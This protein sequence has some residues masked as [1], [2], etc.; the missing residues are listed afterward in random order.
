MNKR[1]PIAD[2]PGLFLANP[3]NWP[4][5]RGRVA[6]IGNGILMVGSAFLL[7]LFA[8]VVI[9]VFMLI[10]HQYF[11]LHSSGVI[12]TGF[13]T[14]LEVNRGSRSTGYQVDYR[15]TVDDRSYT[16]RQSVHPEIFSHLSLHQ[17][18][19]V[20]YLPR[21]PQFSQ[22]HEAEDSP[23]MII[24]FLF[25][26]IFIT[27]AVLLWMKDRHNR[28]L[29]RAGTLILG[30]LTNIEAKRGSKA[31]PY[32]EVRYFFYNEHGIRLEGKHFQVRTDLS[33]DTLP[34]S[35]TP[36]AVLYVDDSTYRLM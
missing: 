33:R 30:E 16:D 26:A 5:V 13:I 11:E 36:V 25:S 10:N 35:G 14:N 15:Y 23:G 29:S 32:I 24:P 19:E 34:P 12:A 2:T 8:V 3:E 31:T 9:I 4:F 1:E 28:Y 21:N 6:R 22:L 27:P 20:R 7:A 17:S 18:V